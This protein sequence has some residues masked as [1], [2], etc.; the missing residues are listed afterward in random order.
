MKVE[1]YT[2]GGHVEFELG[3]DLHWLC[4]TMFQSIL[5]SHL[6]FFSSVNMFWNFLHEDNNLAV[7]HDDYH[8]NTTKT[9]IMSE[10]YSYQRFDVMDVIW[11]PSTPFSVAND[12]ASRE[13]LSFVA[14]F[15]IIYT[16]DSRPTT[17]GKCHRS[18]HDNR[19]ALRFSSPSF[20]KR[21]RG[22][23][24]WLLSDVWCLC[25]VGSA[26]Y[27]NE[28]GAPKLKQTTITPYAWYCITLVG[29]YSLVGA[30][31]TFIF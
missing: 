4:S 11:E 29:S 13:E 27:T 2:Q 26:Y 14:W 3:L 1:N 10:W 30:E 20:K 15:H 9:A 16:Y 22:S 17:H 12:A 24:S 31:P 28:R 8:R 7:I 21:Q 19:K 6:S 25:Q 23:S 5:T 18:S